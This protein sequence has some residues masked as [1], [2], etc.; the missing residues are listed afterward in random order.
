[1][2]AV[3]IISGWVVLQ[4]ADLLFP[5]LEIRDAALRYVWIA[6]LLGFPLALVFAWK[7]D[8]TAQGIRRTPPRAEYAVQELALHNPITC[9]WLG[10]WWSPY[11]P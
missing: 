2:T 4:V 1:M 3:Y 7:Y 9:S 5:A 11:L 6:V 8:I 10:C